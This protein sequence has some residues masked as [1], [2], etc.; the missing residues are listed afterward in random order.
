MPNTGKK[1]ILVVIS[2]LFALTLTVGGGAFGLA[3]ARYERADIAA[4][5]K[6]CENTVYNMRR[7]SENLSAQIAAKQSPQM[8][9]AMAKEKLTQPKFGA[10]IWAY[11]NFQG[12]KVERSAKDDMLISFRPPAPAP[13]KSL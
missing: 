1:N 11:E 4:R 2:L 7:I 6:D 9:R 10:I 5:I 3:A 13:K 8:L 12:G